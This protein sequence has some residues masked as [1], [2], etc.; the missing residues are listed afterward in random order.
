MPAPARVGVWHLTYRHAG[1]MRRQSKA[2][3]F[4]VCAPTATPVGRR[5]KNPA[6]AGY[7]YFWK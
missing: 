5:M 1:R 3:A 4:G 6:E 2:A 7:I